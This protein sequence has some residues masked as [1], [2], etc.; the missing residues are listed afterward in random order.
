MSTRRTGRTAGY[1]M[2]E[3]MMALGIL[4]VGAAGIIALQKA[5]YVSQTQARNLALANSIAMTWAERLRTDA[6]Q[7]NDFNGL[8]DISSTQWLSMPMATTLAPAEMTGLWSPAA[9]VIGRD[10]YTGD[11][12][13]SAFCTHLRLHRFADSQGGV[14]WPDMLRAE[15]RV[16]WERSGNPVDCSVNPDL[17]DNA[18]DRYGAVYL[19]TAVRRNDNRRE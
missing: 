1:T 7:W 14:I 12:S 5:T 18:R 19:T 11:P 13:A 17:V 6:L 8:P 15:I 2:I 10:A 9:D 16:F 3:V 4:A